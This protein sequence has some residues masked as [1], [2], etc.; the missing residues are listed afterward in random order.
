M[1]A[2]LDFIDNQPTVYDINKITNRLEKELELAEKEKEN[3][4]RENPLQFDRTKGYAA[5][6][7]NA[8]EF[9]KAGGKD[10]V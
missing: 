5:G 2:I 6:I 1:K 10:D 4:V 3:A 7:Y 8:L 9:V